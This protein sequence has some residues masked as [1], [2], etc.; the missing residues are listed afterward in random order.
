M[1]KLLVMLLA[2]LLL[3]CGAAMAEMPEARTDT[4]PEEFLGTWVCNATSVDDKYTI[5]RDQLISYYQND[6][7]I[8]WM[9]YTYRDGRLY[10]Q[11]NAGSEAT[12]YIDTVGNL[13]VITYTPEGDE[14]CLVLTRPVSNLPA[15][16]SDVTV[17]DF[18]GEWR[19]H[20][21]YMQGT[22]FDAAELG[23]SG[24]GFTINEDVIILTEDDEPDRTWLVPY[25][26]AVDKL[27]FQASSDM[28][29]YMTEDGMLCIGAPDIDE[30]Y[31]LL[32]RTSEPPAPA[33]AFTFRGLHWGM[34][35]DEVQAVEGQEFSGLAAGSYTTTFGYLE[36]LRVSKFEADIQ[37]IFIENGLAGVGIA[38]DDSIDDLKADA[39]YLL[40]ALTILYGEPQSQDAL[41]AVLFELFFTKRNI[42]EMYVWLPADDTCIFLLIDDEYWEDI[43]VGYYDISHDWLYHTQ[44]TAP[45]TIDT[46]GL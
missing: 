33:G 18:Y 13:C 36:D 24:N 39:D 38:I 11:T 22:L 23:M 42:D 6:E 34:S 27:Y 35:P 30:V 44:T 28:Y 14:A 32:V 20:K 3:L 25:S 17:E 19:L 5:E 26:F 10:A 16:V 31:M 29:M 45:V 2:T 8:F 40:Q 9:E 15:I 4:L 46:T 43:S 41:P 1:K 7:L 21:A 37:Y 12:F